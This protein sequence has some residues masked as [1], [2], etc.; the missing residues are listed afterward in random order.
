MDVNNI[1]SIEESVVLNRTLPSVSKRFYTRYYYVPKHQMIRDTI[2]KDSIVTTHQTKFN[3]SRPLECGYENV[4]KKIKLDDDNM[5]ANSN[6]M[7][8][9]LSSKD[10]IKENKYVKKEYRLTGT[11][12]LVMVHSNKLCVVSLSPLHPVIRNRLVV[13]KVT[14]I[15]LYPSIELQFSELFY[16]ET[17]FGK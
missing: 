4:M 11:E 3:N 6:V 17:S 2:S 9:T 15:I 5:S 7:D 14:Y 12:T 8:A 1:P 10:V 13:T 16:V